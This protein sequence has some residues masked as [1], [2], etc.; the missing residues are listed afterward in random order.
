M[1]NNENLWVIRKDGNL[2]FTTRSKITR[3]QA[4]PDTMWN[5][6]VMLVIVIA[7]CALVDL[8]NFKQVFDAFIFDSL[9]A[10]IV[11]ILAFLIAFDFI[12]I[13]AGLNLKKKT[14]G[15]KVNTTVIKIMMG[16]FAL[17]FVV[18]FALRIATREMVLPEGE[19][20]SGVIN[21]DVAMPEPQQGNRMLVYVYAVLTS[22]VPLITSLA[23]GGIS[24]LMSNPLQRERLELEKRK[25]LLLSDIES[26]NATLAEYDADGEYYERMLAEDAEKYTAAQQM[27][28]R[29]RQHLKDYVREQLAEHLADPTSTTVLTAKNG[30]ESVDP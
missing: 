1:R 12:P 6:P 14:Q 20:F 17:A 3:L 19:V 24:F 23:S 8:L 25:N 16:A 2:G 27:V 28:E 29:H 15:Y 18:N 30:S 21:G 10:R 4:R 26:V 7:A 9:I 5:H 13:W 22:I 11:G